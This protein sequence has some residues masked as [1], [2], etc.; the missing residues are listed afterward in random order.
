[1][2]IR[3]LQFEMKKIWTSMLFKVLVILFLMSILIYYSYVYMKTIRIEDITAQLNE[4]IIQAEQQLESMDNQASEDAL[5]FQELLAK[6]EAVLDAYENERW[7]DVLQFE[8]DA[9]A[10]LIEVPI[11]NKQYYT[12]SFPTL[13]TME[14]RRD[15]FQYLQ[16]HHIQPILPIHPYAWQTIYDEYY[17]ANDSQDDAFLKGYVNEQSNLNSSTAVYFIYQWA[18]LLFGVPGLL[19]FLFLFGD[20]I[21]KEGLNTNGSVYLLR[22]QPIRS[23]TIPLS[24]YV[25]IS[26]V[27]LLIFALA[28][29]TSLVLGA[30]FDRVGEWNYPVLIY[31]ESYSFTFMPMSNYLSKVFIL[32]FCAL[33]FSYALLFFWSYITKRMILAVG[34]TAATL[35]AGWQ[36]SKQT[37]HISIAP[38]VPFHYLSPKSIITMVYAVE[39]ENFLYTF[40]TGVTVLLISSVVVILLTYIFNVVSERR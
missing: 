24:K 36:L 4:T 31:G 40:E 11:A 20:V 17:P 8:L 33:L 15:Y 22:T 18:G 1:M 38:Y 35:I 34:I 26:G 21:T 7:H 23:W 2:M 39:T 16:Q 27:T 32:F 25:T 30:L 37:L 14:T 13:F 3:L 28:T 12:S 6:D 5:F 19:F 10:E 9:F 29:L